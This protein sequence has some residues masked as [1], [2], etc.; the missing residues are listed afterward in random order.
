MPMT[1]NIAGPA[2]QDDRYPLPIFVF[3]VGLLGFAVGGAL[4][5]DPRLQRVLPTG[6]IAGLMLVHLVLH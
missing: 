2:M 5:G 1:R 6:A 3:L 4:L